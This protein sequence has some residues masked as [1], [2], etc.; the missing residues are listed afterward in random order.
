MFD[1]FSIIYVCVQVRASIRARANC[2]RTHSCDPTTP[3]LRRFTRWLAKGS[4]HTQGVQAEHWSPGKTNNP[5]TVHWSSAEFASVHNAGINIFEL[6][7]ISWLESR[8][9]TSLGLAALRNASVS[10]TGAHALAADIESRF[11]ALDPAAPSVSELAVVPDQERLKTLACGSTG[12][13][14]RFAANGTITSLSFGQTRGAPQ[15]SWG[16]GGAAGL[17]LLELSY[18]TY[19]TS[20]ES[21]DG[22]ANMSCSEPGCAN[23][24]SRVWSP[25]LGRVWRNGTRRESTTVMSS[26]GTSSCRFVAELLFAPALSAKYGA[27]THATVELVLDPTSRSMEASLVWYNKTATRLPESLMVSFRPAAAAAAAASAAN[28]AEAEAAEAFTTPAAAV[29]GEWELD[30][31]GG[32]TSPYDVGGGTT[33]QYVHAIWSG[34]RYMTQGGGI[35]LIESLDA[36]L[37][38]PILNRTTIAAREASTFLL[39]G[40]TPIGEGASSGTPLPRGSVVGMAFNLYNNLMPISGFAQWYPFGAKGTEFYQEK[41]E[42][43]LFR[44]RLSEMSN[45]AIK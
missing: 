15:S 2:V 32:W 12:A 24:E 37:A 31:L 38:C 10:D 23:P 21:W 19:N 20:T 17:G 44:F 16:G 14:L 33:E 1:F 29:A 28:A 42:A 4:E 8:I 36:P 11:L 22:R 27:P 18:V 40:S 41:D 30:I 9:F 45:V 3:A 39:G 26:G 5:D 34:A 43:S 6:G 25:L 35:L 7:E 13:G